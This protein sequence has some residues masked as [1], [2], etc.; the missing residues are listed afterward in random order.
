MNNDLLAVH[1]LCFLGVSAMDP[2][3]DAAGIRQS[4]KVLFPM[5]AQK[6]LNLHTQSDA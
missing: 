3:V 5:L 2:A 4:G 6:G 1:G